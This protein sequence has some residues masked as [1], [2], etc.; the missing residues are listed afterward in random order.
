LDLLS[1]LQKSFKQTLR[2]TKKQTAEI[3]AS[4]QGC[5]DDPI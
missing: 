4:F 3:T 5:N 2:F 1:D